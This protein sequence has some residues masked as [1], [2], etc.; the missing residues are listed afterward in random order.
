M[1][2]PL[3]ELIEEIDELQILEGREDVTVKNG[4]V[5]DLLSDVMRNAA[6]GS[7]WV[8]VQHHENVVAVALMADISAIVFS[9]G[10]KP[11]QDVIDRGREEEI[12]LCSFPGTSYEL[13]GKL[14]SMGI[15]RNK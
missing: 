7:I 6:E 13:V 1:K 8:T 15:G 3:S 12:T 9:N 11:D 5:S 2:I 14:Y 10:L 4:Y